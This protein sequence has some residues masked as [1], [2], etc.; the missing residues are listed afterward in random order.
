M[1]TQPQIRAKTKRVTR[2]VGWF[3]LKP[4]QL[5]QGC[6][7]C[8]GIPPGGRMVKLGVIRVESAVGEPLRRLID[9][10][11]YGAAE[12]ILEGFPEMTPEEFVSFFC[13]SHKGCTPDTI[14]CRIAFDYVT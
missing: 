2:R 9:D 12:V 1:L 11:A 14:V 3:N 7:K 5:L 8:Q 4:G 6:E 13:K 10:P